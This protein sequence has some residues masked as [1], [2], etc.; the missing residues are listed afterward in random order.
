MS[1]DWSD[2]LKA[3][4]R[5]WAQIGEPW[6]PHFAITMAA[7][8][9]PL[10][11]LYLLP[12][13]LGLFAPRL[14]PR[15]DLY[16]VNRPIA[17]SFLDAAGND[18][19]HRGAIV[20]ER[21]KLEEMPAYLPAAFVA[22]EDRRF[23]SHNGIDPVGLT[24]ALLRDLRAGHWV[25]GGSTI[26]QQTAKIVYTQ[27]ERTVSRKLA[28]LVDAAGLEE[29]LSK[30]QILELYL[31]RLYLGSASYG[32]DGAA[33]TYF[34]V[35]A[36]NVTLAQAA[37][38]ATLTRAP[39]V[40]SPRRD[41]LAAQQR[42]TW[43]L[44]AMVET[45]SITEAQAA[46]A[47]AHP[48]I[49]I[50][51]AGLDARNYFLDTA[52]DEAKRLAGPRASGDLIVH[53]TLEPKLQEAAR[54]AALHAI[55]K[56][57]RRLKVSE[58]AAVMMHP[59]GAVAALI[60]GTDYSA[61]VFNRA[62]Q[63]RRQPGSAFKPFVYLAALEDG[64]S[65]WDTREDVP[66][67]INGYKPA[68]FGNNEYGTLTLADALAHSVNTITVNLA[69]EVG[70]PKI[71]AAARRLGI[72]SPLA[73]NASLALGTS[74]VIPL[75]LT[76]AY[77]SFAN[78][79]FA[80]TPY[81]VTQVDG[82]G[83]TQTY[84]R[85]TAPPPRRVIDAV[86]NRDMLAMLWNVVVFGTG[87][88]ARLP[89][90]E[91]GGKTG[92]TQDSHDAWFI[93][94]TTDYVAGVW[95]GNDDSSPTR[96]VTGGTLPAAIWKEA[97]LAA[98]K[99]LPVHGLDRSP[100]QEAREPLLL[101]ASDPD[102]LRDDESGINGAIPVLNTPRDQADE[103]RAASPDQPAPRRRGGGILGWLFGSDADSEPPPPPPLPPRPE[104]PP[105]YPQ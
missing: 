66:V 59:D 62:T 84:Y 34:G 91:A 19:G 6:A 105:P 23:Y 65:P 13:F 54:L 74:E 101:T 64:I 45:G 90:R 33:R 41:L 71:I 20:G 29:S 100:P 57:G 40:F 88:S 31:N 55:N 70:I 17:F 73:D 16:A 11:L 87:A 49:V 82:A 78:G 39:S 63:A 94:F 35:S 99:G 9:V 25:A 32:V 56:S 50:D 68:N 12:Q 80:V 98:E 85:R 104:A 14:D 28:E 86:V 3:R 58:A 81:F 67:D 27:Q 30:K 75:E 5:H 47:R 93:G 22:M 96:G 26:S 10:A 77:A 15:L 97:M 43:V 51:R 76:A 24:R 7:L 103:D 52:A 83:G 60:G 72:T 42:A 69:Q 36:R 92:T 102:G 95:V 79:G 38:L 2:Q 46:D 53:T 1:D 61:S 4:L 21:L 89:D 18:A 37:M 48:A 44:D 8:A